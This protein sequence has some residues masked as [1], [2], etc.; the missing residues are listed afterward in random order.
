[1]VVFFYMKFICFRI[2]S[3]EDLMKVST[4]KFKE[5]FNKTH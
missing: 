3:L 1:M 2:Y 5:L 4:L